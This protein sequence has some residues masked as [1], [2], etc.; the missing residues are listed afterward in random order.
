MISFG[1]NDACL[2]NTTGQHV[3]LELYKQNLRDIAMH[4]S[5]TAHQ[6]RLILVTPPP[7]DEALHEASGLAKGFREPRRTAEHTKLYANACRE[8]GAE[9]QIAV[10]DL[11]SIFAELAGWRGGLPL[12]GSKTVASNDLLVALLRDG[13]HFTPKGYHLL[14]EVVLDLI[15]QTWPDQ[16]PASLPFVFPDWQSF[17]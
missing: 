4:P 3:P 12:V 10:L 17:L 14:Y 2:P 13:L 1:A 5:I 8:V 16:H 11:W 15:R 6:P 9:L 7:I